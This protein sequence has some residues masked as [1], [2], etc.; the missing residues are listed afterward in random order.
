[1]AFCFTPLGISAAVPF[2]NRHL[3]AHVLQIQNELFLIDCGEGTIFQLQKFKIKYNSINHVFISHLHGDH[4]FGLFGFLTTLAMNGR[5]ESLHIYSPLGLEEIIHTVFKFSNYRSPYPIIFFAVESEHSISLI[6]NNIFSVCSFPLYHRIPTIGFYF[7]E[8]PLPLNLRSE[9]IKKFAIP[10][11]Q[12]KNIKNGACYFE[13]STNTLIPNSEL[14]LPP[15]K[16]R[17]FAYCSDTRYEPSLIKYFKNVDL[18]YH[19]STFLNDMAEHAFK[20]GHTTALQA[21]QI[22]VLANAQKLIIGHF[23]ARYTELKILEDEARTI[24]ENTEL[25]EEGKVFLVELKRE[26]ERF[27]KEK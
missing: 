10:F 24:F 13:E 15:Y 4:F 3:A 5:K 18:L 19:E 17:S 26:K 7:E 11:N 20:V 22:A 23:S 21:A 2:D 27:F 6:E 25:S 9:V 12:L 16:P 8:K 14:T 1:M